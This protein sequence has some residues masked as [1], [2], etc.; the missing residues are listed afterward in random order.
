MNF[1]GWIDFENV[2]LY[3]SRNAYFHLLILGKENDQVQFKN[4][5]Q[6]EA[7]FVL[8]SG[9]PINEQVVQHGPFVMTTK[10]EI[11]QTI[12]DYQEGK[13]GFEMAH[14]WKSAEGN[15]FTPF[16]PKKQEW[17]GFQSQRLRNE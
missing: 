2:I 4:D 9:Q 13:N 11:T 6:S 1:N 5:G 12:K 16:E 7:R 17:K 10:Q 3:I 8:I 14:K 15:K